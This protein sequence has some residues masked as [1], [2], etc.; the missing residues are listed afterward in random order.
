[1]IPLPATVT[2][3]GIWAAIIA[4]AFAILLA[5][6]GVQTVRIEGFKI[7]PLSIEGWKPKAERLQHD[8][9]AVKAA[10][11]VALEK[12]QAAKAKAELDYKNLAE[13][14][15]ANEQKARADAMAGAERYITDHRVR[16]QAA[17]GS[18]G[19]TAPAAEDHGATGGNSAGAAP[20]LD[21]VTV[22]ADDIRICTVNTTRLEAVRD[23][24]IDLSSPASSPTH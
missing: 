11:Q 20:E 3:K 8:L 1:V 14:T 13:T 9:D 19:R 5:L 2:L 12:A 23:W 18:A 10:Q 21:E 22:T 24:A 15:D 17:G 7:W 16:P 4:L 6:L